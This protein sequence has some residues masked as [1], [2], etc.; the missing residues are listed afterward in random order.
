M[1]KENRAGKIDIDSIRKIYDYLENFEREH[2]SDLN[3]HGEHIIH[4]EYTKRL[5]K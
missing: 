3:A 1:I 4:E 2:C 5:L